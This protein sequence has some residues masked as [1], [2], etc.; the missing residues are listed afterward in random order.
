MKTRLLRMCGS[1]VTRPMAVIT[2]SN[3]P[4]LIDSFASE[5]KNVICSC[6]PCHFRF[7]LTYTTYH[8]IDCLLTALWEMIP[9]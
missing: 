7:C 4:V 3:R 5:L 9:A 8:E 2:F 6:C 1:V